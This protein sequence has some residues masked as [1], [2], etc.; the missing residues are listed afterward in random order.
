MKKV[1]IGLIAAAMLLGS[2]A[3]AEEVDDIMMMNTEGKI[4]AAMAE[5]KYF[6]MLEDIEA[7]ITRLNKIQDSLQNAE[8]SHGVIPAIGQEVT[9][10]SQ[11][12]EG[13]KNLHTDE[14]DKEAKEVR[15]HLIRFTKQV[16]QII[17]AQGL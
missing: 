4:E 12:L 17:K 11:K 1:L 2:F 6:T 14:T 8:D 7:S 16:E 10:A 5:T 13:F 9:V 15:S 3:K